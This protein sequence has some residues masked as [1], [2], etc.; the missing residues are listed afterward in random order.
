MENLWLI[1]V[2]FIFRATFGLSLAMAV[3][4]ANKV[5]SG[6]YRVHLW[7]LMGICTFAVPAIYTVTNSLA[8]GQ[9]YPRNG[10]PF[11]FNGGF[12]YARVRVKY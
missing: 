6:Y 1:L 3:T 4:P 7:V 9:V 8:D 12:W 5:T 10:G 2:Q 11:G